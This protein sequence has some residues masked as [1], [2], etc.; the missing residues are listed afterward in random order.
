MLRL[1]DVERI[2]GD[3]IGAPVPGGRYAK[4]PA[5]VA[6]AAELAGYR[7]PSAIG[8]SCRRG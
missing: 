2:A 5:V 4:E 3:A 8:R 1:A 6:G 7:P